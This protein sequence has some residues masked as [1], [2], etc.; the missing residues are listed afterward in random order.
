MKYYYLYTNKESHNSDSDIYFYSI[1]SL[2]LSYPLLS[3][4]TF[5]SGGWGFTTLFPIKTH[6]SFKKHPGIDHFMAFSN[7]DFFPTS[8]FPAKLA[9]VDIQAQSRQTIAKESRLST[10]VTE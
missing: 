10:V 7:G 6:R 4:T 1:L 2:P 3:L 9:I 8:Q 5:S